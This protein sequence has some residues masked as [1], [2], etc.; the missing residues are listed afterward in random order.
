MAKNKSE[1]KNIRELRK[2]A[3]QKLRNKTAKQITDQTSIEEIAMELTVHQIE[4][5]MQ[6][7]QLH[8][9]QAELERSHRKYTDLFD[10]APIGY[11][12]LNKKGIIEEVNLAG[13]GLLGEERSSIVNK[14]FSIYVDSNDH[15]ILYSFYHRIY[16]G[17]EK[18]ECEIKLIRKDK[19]F[20]F[21]R[22]ISE[23]VKNADD[24]IDRSRLAV[25]DITRKVQ[26]E[27]ELRELAEEL[28][29][30][31][32]ELE[33][34][35]DI[36]SHDLREPLRAIT[37]F[38]ELL[39]MKYKQQLDEQANDYIQYAINGGKTMKNM[40]L[41]LLE[42]SRIQSRGNEFSDVDVNKALKDAIDGLQLSIAESGAEIANDELP[43]VRADESQLT[44]LLQNMIQNAIKFR[45]R[46][47]PK[48][49]IGCKREKK[50]WVF[51]VSDNGIGIEQD[52]QKHMFTIFQ[53][54]HRGGKYE[55]DGVGL[56]VCK[57]IVERH[58]GK[59]WVESEEGKGSTFY[60]TLPA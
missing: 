30:S 47:K 18:A 9:I 33:E 40:I 3:K 27:N 5:E 54:Q 16:E 59:I 20:I 1:P 26:A 51:S 22:L 52:F 28:K 48:I 50:E 55:G 34:F 24:K 35:A 6:N 10:F 7:E 4:L 31:N 58:R 42:Y 41:G 46:R 15:N 37:G 53:R 11:F 43:K 2:L 17:E 60:F 23:P 29:R 14:P 39:Q 32:T 44:Q 57:R 25:V 38:V 45:S 36:V 13:A 12:V 8:E 19:D 56:A 21:V 49:H